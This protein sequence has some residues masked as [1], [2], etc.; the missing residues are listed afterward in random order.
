MP[1][2]APFSQATS[3][4]FTVNLP[5]KRAR[6]PRLRSRSPSTPFTASYS[7]RIAR[8]SQSLSL[9]SLSILLLSKQH[10]LSSLS[11]SR[12]PRASP[13][14][15][16][17]CTRSASRV[18]KQLFFLSAASSHH[19]YI[20]KHRLLRRSTLRLSSRPR[21]TSL[22]RTRRMPS[23]NP[24]TKLWHFGK[25]FALLAFLTPVYGE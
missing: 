8:E 13:F 5:P 12:R 17:T 2:P 20:P 22:R 16:C 21:D 18:F 15:R 14:C 19:P 25:T 7:Q 10:F 3:L 1:L 24:F 11:A 23:S 6:N 4:L 9:Q